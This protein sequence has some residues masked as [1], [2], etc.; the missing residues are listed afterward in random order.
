MNH[1][2]LKNKSYVDLIN[3]VI[4]EEAKRYAV[5][6]YKVLVQYIERNWDH[7]VFTIYDDLVLGILFSRIRGESIEFSSHLKRKHMEK[8][9]M[10]VNTLNN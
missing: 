8:E 7:I 6:V 3:N 10:P 2:L 4:K 1:S 5:P 9:D